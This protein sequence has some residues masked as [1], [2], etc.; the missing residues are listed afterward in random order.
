MNFRQILCKDQKLS[1]AYFII[2]KMTISNS[3][4]FEV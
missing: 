4:K 2:S 3:H 1:D